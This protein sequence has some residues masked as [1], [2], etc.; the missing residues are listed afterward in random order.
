MRSR[1][2]EKRMRKL[3]SFSV[4]EPILYGPKNA[5]IT[6]VGF[7]SVKGAVLDGMK[8]LE[9]QG[10]KANFLHFVY[11]L[12]FPESAK[13]ILSKAKKL[14]DVECNFTAQFAGVIAQNTGILIEKKLLKYDGRPFYPEEIAEFAKKVL[15][16]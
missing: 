3:E 2:M 16:K 8:I 15:R 5:G 10:I 13:A 14:V 6:F 4:P 7:G 9:S 11:I 1:M 12:P